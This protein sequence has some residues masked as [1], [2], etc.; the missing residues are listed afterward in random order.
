MTAPNAAATDLL[1]ID[2]S[3]PA[4]PSM[5][6][7]SVVAEDCTT[8]SGR[9]DAWASGPVVAYRLPIL[10]GG[11]VSL[12]LVEA[13]PQRRLWLNAYN[14]GSARWEGWQQV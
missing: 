4:D 2:P 13:V 7:G 1:L 10:L 11:F 6:P 8:L 3:N 14:A 12:V 9:P 5:R